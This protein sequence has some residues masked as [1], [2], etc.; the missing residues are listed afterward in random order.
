MLHWLI[1]GGGL[2]GTHMALV[3]TKGCSIDSRQVRVLDP[4]PEL[5]APPSVSQHYPAGRK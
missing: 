2:H 3:L 4:E 1:I 5:L